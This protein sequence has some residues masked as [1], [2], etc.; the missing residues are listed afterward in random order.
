MTYIT[1][2]SCRYNEKF[3][4]T[5]GR[6][7]PDL[8]GRGF[9]DGFPELWPQMKGVFDQAAA[10]AQTVDV[11]NI[12]LFPERKGNFPEE[13]YWIGQFI[14]LRDDDGKIGGFYNTVY[15]NTDRIL[16]ERRRLVAENIAAMPTDSVYETVTLVVGALRDNPQDIPMCLLYSYVDTETDDESNLHCVGRI[17]VPDDHPCAPREAILERSRTGFIEHF[18]RVRQTGKPVLLSQ[19]DNSLASVG[20]LEGVSWCGYG[21]PSRDIVVLHLSSGG[22][23]LGFLV[24]AT[25]PRRLYDEDT[26]RSIVD[27]A[28]QIEAKWAASI[29]VEQYQ[30]REQILEQRATNS[31]NRLQHMAMHAPV[32]MCQV[33]QFQ[34]QS[35][36]SG[37]SWCHKLTCSYCVSGRSR[38]NDTLRQRPI[39]RDHRPRSGEA[40]HECKREEVSP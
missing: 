8:L 38:P 13:T 33:R 28:R 30:A 31:E 10:S 4:V 36:T 34:S 17:A 16:H 7:H 5:A 9:E 6:A 25:N 12:L 18:R 32:G 21:E 29:S 24:V 26:E 3:G 37:A 15:E 20:T 19:S 27:I 14:P 22:T 40:A 2:F 35:R 23:L 11:D 39:L 1:D